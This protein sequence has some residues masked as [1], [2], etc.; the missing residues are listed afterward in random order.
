MWL[1][2][3]I[4][5][6]VIIVLLFGW[7]TRGSLIPCEPSALHPELIQYIEKNL[8]GE[9]K[10]RYEVFFSG[11]TQ[12][13]G[14]KQSVQIYVNLKGSHLLIFDYWEIVISKMRSGFPPPPSSL[15]FLFGHQKYDVQRMV[16][17]NILLEAGT[18]DRRCLT[19]RVHPF[20]EDKVP[21]NLRLCAL[22]ADTGIEDILSKHENFFDDPDGNNSAFAEISRQS[23][24]VALDLRKIP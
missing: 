22:G 24:V 23:G 14:F 18:R 1:S 20:V 10:K 11:R 13:G 4:L 8:C 2:A 9:P 21:E 7:R 15:Y 6:L 16:R 5:V 17:F 19:C 12:V 3:A